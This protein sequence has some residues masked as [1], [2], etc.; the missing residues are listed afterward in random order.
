[1]NNSISNIGESVILQPGHNKNK[2][3]TSTLYGRQVLPAY[4]PYTK[5][6]LHLCQC[7]IIQCDYS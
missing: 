2:S 1:M 5:T 6:H 4:L 7:N 3:D